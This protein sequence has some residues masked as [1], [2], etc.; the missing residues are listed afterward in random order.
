VCA[1]GPKERND[2]SAELRHYEIAV[3]GSPKAAFAAARPFKERER[4]PGIYAELS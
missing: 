2:I 1:V 4:K 3:F